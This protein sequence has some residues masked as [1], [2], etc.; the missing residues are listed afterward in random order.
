MHQN[1]ALFLCAEHKHFQNTAIILSIHHTNHNIHVY[2]HSSTSQLTETITHMHADINMAL[3]PL[4]RNT[5]HICSVFVCSGS[6]THERNFRAHNRCWGAM[7]IS[8]YLRNRLPC[9]LFIQTCMLR[10][11]KFS[12][13]LFCAEHKWKMNLL[14]FAIR[15]S[16]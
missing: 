5:E 4:E 1:D 16:N 14:V 3:I 12:H 10:V 6:A 7:D 13:T 2:E 8:M 11:S 15:D 9:N